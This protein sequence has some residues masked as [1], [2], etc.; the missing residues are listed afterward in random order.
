[1][2]LKDCTFEP[3]RKKSF[4]LCKQSTL[5]NYVSLHKSK[6]KK[7][8]IYIYL[9]VSSKVLF[10]LV[11]IGK[12]HTLFGLSWWL[13]NKKNLPPSAGHAR[14]R[15][16]IPG[17]RRSSGELSGYLLPFSC[18]EN[19]MDT[20]AWWATVIRVAEWDMIKWLRTHIIVLLVHCILS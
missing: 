6:R 5:D 8:Y 9:R 11:F 13:R 2:R 19:F 7:K 4:I 12:S 15:D 20:G 18:L 10:V 16:L 3:E 14:D 1:M 17:W